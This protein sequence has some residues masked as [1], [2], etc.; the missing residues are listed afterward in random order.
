MTIT[1]RV[2]HVLDR[3]YL[4]GVYLKV[5]ESWRVD[6]AHERLTKRE[7]LREVREWV[8]DNGPWY[9]CGCELECATEQAK[10]NFPNSYREVCA[11]VDKWFPALGK[12][13]S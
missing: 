8:Q 9:G 2:T 5:V 1:V 7:L 4:I 11:Q 13:V 3:D 10:E 6:G 12:G